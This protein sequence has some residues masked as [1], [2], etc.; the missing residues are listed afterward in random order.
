MRYLVSALSCL[1]A[2]GCGSEGTSDDATGTDVPD[3]MDALDTSDTSATSDA[4][5]PG[6]T[7]IRPEV[8]TAEIAEPLDTPLGAW[9]WFDSPGSS[10]HDGSETG[11]AVNRGAGDDVLVVLMGGG[12][13]WDFTT[14]FVVQSAAKGPFQRA[15]FDAVADAIG[16]GVLDRDDPANPYRDFSFVFVPYCTGDLHAGERAVDYTQGG[17]TATW[18]HMGARNIRLMLPRLAATFP[19]PTRLVVAGLSAGGYGATLQYAAF[20]AAFA[21]AQAQ[22]VDDSGPLLP[23][24]GIPATYRAA[25]FANWRLDQVVDPICGQLCKT[26]LS[27]FYPALAA[28]FPDDRMALVVSLQD[29]V[30]AAYFGMLGV[31]LEARLEELATD[32]L[33]PLPGFRTFMFAGTSHTTLASPQSFTVKGRDL[34]SWL[35]L[36]LA[37]DPGWISLAPD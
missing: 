4:I 29:Q 28:R 37:G 13:C 18:H 2:F 17:I 27:A 12:A 31:Q 14:C 32:V 7:L 36:M 11:F 30:I 5:D 1:L 15:Q 35:G 19:S 3:V 10:C 9:T 8:D 25:W 22:L 20:R 26:D 21:P 33:A 24:D 16:V 34:R 23:G 6:D